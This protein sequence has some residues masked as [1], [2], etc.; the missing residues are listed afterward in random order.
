MGPR[1]AIEM[2]ALLGT[3]L[4]LVSSCADEKPAIHRLSNLACEMSLDS[5]NYKAL[6]QREHS[7][8]IVWSNPILDVPLGVEYVK[9]ARYIYAST[10]RAEEQVRFDTLTLRTETGSQMYKTLMYVHSEYSAEM[11]FYLISPI[12]FNDEPSTPASFLLYSAQGPSI[13]GPRYDLM[14]DLDSVT[15]REILGSRIQ[16]PIKRSPATIELGPL[17]VAFHPNELLLRSRI[18]GVELREYAHWTK[19]VY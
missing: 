12:Q 8:T 16:G 9:R 5:V 15:C 14:T 18:N 6:A 2:I 7:S 13:D 1:S 19:V 11:I 3:L 17:T 4:A 10:F